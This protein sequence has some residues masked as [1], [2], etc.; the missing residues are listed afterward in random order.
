MAEMTALANKL[1]LRLRITH[2]SK[3]KPTPDEISRNIKIIYIAPAR[4]GK[5]G[6]DQVGHAY[7]VEENGKKSHVESKPNDCFY[8][9]CGKILRTQGHVKSVDELRQL[10]AKAI[11][12]NKCFFKVLDGEKLIQN[13]YPEKAHT[14]LFSAGIL[15][16]EDV[17]G[18][19]KNLEVEDDD[20]QKLIIYMNEGKNKLTYSCGDKYR[21]FF[22]VYSKFFLLF[23]YRLIRLTKTVD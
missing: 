1:G 17:Y 20:V 5:N 19:T 22:K 12:S 16:H 18:N 3:T 8:A 10:T 14:L 13:R 6:L 7:F 4:K 11:E 21:F 2:D 9:V 23:I 15:R